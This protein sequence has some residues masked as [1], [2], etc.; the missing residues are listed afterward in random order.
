MARRRPKKTI[1]Q[2]MKDR[3]YCGGCR[4]REEPLHPQF[5]LCHRCYTIVKTRGR[6]NG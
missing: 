6:K 5:G 1:R 2:V 4:T 3:D